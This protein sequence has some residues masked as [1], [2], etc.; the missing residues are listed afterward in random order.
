MLPDHMSNTGGTT[1]PI[2][3]GT[4]TNPGIGTRTGTGTDTGTG[5]GTGSNTGINNP[6]FGLGPSGNGGF[7]TD[8]SGSV[9]LHQ[10]KVLFTIAFLLT[11]SL[12]VCLRV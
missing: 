6:A 1:T 12:V 11:S 2:A 7:N 9:T 8:G 3:P 5:T 4:T 10:N